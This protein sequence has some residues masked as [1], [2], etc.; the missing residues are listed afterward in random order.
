MYDC[1]IHTQYSFS[2]E[3]SKHKPNWF[4]FFCKSPY[5]SVC[6]LVPNT[7]GKGNQK[8]VLS[9]RR[10]KGYGQRFEKSWY[11]RDFYSIFNYDYFNSYAKNGI[12]VNV[13]INF[14]KKNCIE[15]NLIQL[16]TY[17]VFLYFD[18]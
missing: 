17:Y 13:I 7:F 8:K 11:C 15:N 4:G 6:E 3:L 5:Y 9:F 14:F 1:Y 12:G 2:W 10:L 18:H 16:N